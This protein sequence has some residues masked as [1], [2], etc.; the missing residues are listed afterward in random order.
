MTGRLPVNP[1]DYATGPCDARVY[2][3]NDEYRQCSAEAPFVIDPYIREI[4]NEESWRYL[5]DKHFIQR[6]D[7]I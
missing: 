3:G 4:Y 6:A 5:C 2:V 7:D 1:G